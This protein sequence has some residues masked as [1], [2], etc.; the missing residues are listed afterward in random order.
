MN[1]G[2]LQVVCA[3]AHQKQHEVTA[4]SAS[5]FAHR[6]TA[7]CHACKRS[8][9]QKRTMN[10]KLAQIQV[11]TAVAFTATFLMVVQKNSDGRLRWQ[12]L[13]MMLGPWRGSIKFSWGQPVS[14]WKAATWCHEG[15]SNTCVHA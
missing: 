12:V 10:M 14:H 9:S 5:L 4:R 7:L 2:A 11:A 1:E 13:T 15:L 3:D 8:D 6:I